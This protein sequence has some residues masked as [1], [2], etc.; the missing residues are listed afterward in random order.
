VRV[1]IDADYAAQHVLADGV[2]VTVRHIRPS[3]ADE[4]RRAYGRLSPQSR[5]RRFLASMPALSEEMIRYLT[6]VDGQG[7]VALVAT[8]E[9]H[10]LKSEVG[11]GVA[12]FIRLRE[13]PDVAEAAV[14]VVDEMQRK[15]IGR[16]LTQTLGEAALERGVKRFRGEVLADNAPMRRLLEDAGAVVRDDE[17][18]TLV[19]D[20]PLQPEVA[21]ERQSPLRRMLRIAA[22]FVAALRAPA[23]PQA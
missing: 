22:E 3:D 10:D 13:E 19:F 23:P 2:R 20:V 18:G 5:Y 11:L 6:D 7:H 4:L 9:S 15:G 12:R 17:G 16:I 1:K 21:V 14:T 8:C